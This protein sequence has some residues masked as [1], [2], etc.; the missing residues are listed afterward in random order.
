MPDIT[1][2]GGAMNLATYS[3]LYDVHVHMYLIMLINVRFC[4]ED[5]L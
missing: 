5:F 4:P 1:F 2:G 3:V